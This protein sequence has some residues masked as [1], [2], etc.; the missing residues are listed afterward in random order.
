MR[1]VFVSAALTLTAAMSVLP[2]QVANAQAPSISIIIP[3]NH[4][5]ISG[6]AQDLDATASSGVTQVK[7]DITGGTR[8]GQ[9]TSSVRRSRST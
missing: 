3:S 7:F 9:T 2:S 4:A 1:I 5:T 8:G 6:T